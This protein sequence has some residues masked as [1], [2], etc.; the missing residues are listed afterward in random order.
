[1][2]RSVNDPAPNQPALEA[3]SISGSAIAAAMTATDAQNPRR[4]RDIF[5]D[6]RLPPA[7][8]SALSDS[9]SGGSG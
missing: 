6:F 1:L 2:L 3:N 7:G 9:L 5:K 4:A 8:K